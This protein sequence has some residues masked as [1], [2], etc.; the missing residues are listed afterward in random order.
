MCLRKVIKTH[1]YTVLKADNYEIARC[2]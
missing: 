2:T 1:W